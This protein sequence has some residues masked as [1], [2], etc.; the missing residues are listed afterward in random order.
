MNYTR[1]DPF[2]LTLSCK[3][4]RQLSPVI[5]RS[6]GKQGASVQRA[7]DAIEPFQEA[8]RYTAGTSAAPLIKHV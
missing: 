7:V 2:Q 3:M 4:Q 8:G 5:D 1:F 6:L